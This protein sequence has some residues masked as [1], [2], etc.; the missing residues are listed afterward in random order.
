MSE[1]I[2]TLASLRAARQ[3][4]TLEMDAMRAAS[5]ERLVFSQEALR[6]TA[7]HVRA[8]APPWPQDVFWNQSA[9]PPRAG[10]D[11][12]VNLAERTQL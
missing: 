11:H 3:R 5:R 1:L 6:T 4:A 9:K 2:Y 10:C 7:P 8:G 12:G